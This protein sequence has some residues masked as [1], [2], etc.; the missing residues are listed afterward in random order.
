M[1]SD[2]HAIVIES[3]PASATALA[4]RS[5]E[6][7]SRCTTFEPTPGVPDSSAQI[8]D[9]SAGM[10]VTGPSTVAVG[11]RLAPPIDQWPATIVAT[12]STTA[13]A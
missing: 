10:S 9:V 12:S 1:L 8:D 7:E 11:D 13:P 4:T 2:A 3:G 6:I 5:R